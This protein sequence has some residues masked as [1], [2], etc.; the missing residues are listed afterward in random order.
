MFKVL[1]ADDLTLMANAPDAMQAMLNTYT[2]M[3]KKEK[4]LQAVKNHSSH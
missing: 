1:L 2:G 4:T 3:G